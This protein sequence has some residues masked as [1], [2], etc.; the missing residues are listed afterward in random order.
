VTRSI[1]V[2]AE[3]ECFPLWLDDGD[4]LDPRE[5]PISDTLAAE[6]DEWRAAYDE[7]FDR[8]DPRSSEFP[9]T[10]AADEFVARGDRLAHRLAV[11]LAGGYAVRYFDV[12][13]GGFTDIEPAAPANGD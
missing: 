3:Y 4:N 9:T 11:E 5:L 13:T 6:L 10:D 2:I 8:E 12:R 1:R 7:T